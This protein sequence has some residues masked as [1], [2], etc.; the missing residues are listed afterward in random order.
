VVGFIDS[1][2]PPIYEIIGFLIPT[3][4]K[5]DIQYLPTNI[6]HEK[7]IIMPEINRPNMLFLKIISDKEIVK[8]ARIDI[9]EG[10]LLKVK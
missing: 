8:I 10:S 7:A 1:I 4:C 6:P 2:V 3:T 9:K 5:F